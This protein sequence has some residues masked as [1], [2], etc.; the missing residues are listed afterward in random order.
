M[1]WSR[2]G[3][4]TAG[5]CLSLLL[6]AVAG[7]SAEPIVITSSS[8]QIIVRG[9]PVRQPQDA[10]LAGDSLLWLNREFAGSFWGL[11]PAA[12]NNSLVLLDPALLAVTGENIRQTLGRKLDWGS[13]WRGRI[14]INLHPVRFDRETILV[15]SIRSADGWNYELEMPDEVDAPRLVRTL[16]EV[17]LMEFANRTAGER[18]SELPPWLGPG[19]AACLRSG[20]LEVG[21]IG[22]NH[23][24][25]RTRIQRDPMEFI[26]AGLRANPVLT[27]DQLNWPA[28]DQFEE[29]KAEQ[30]DASAHLLVRELLRLGGGAE[31]LR[32]T[33]RLLPQH[34]NW[35]TAF[36]RGFQA[37]FQRMLD[38][39]KWWS[40]VV[41]GFT[42]RDPDQTWSS[43]E[44]RQR[45]DEVLYTLVQVRL[46]KDEMP[47]ESQVSLQTVLLE[48]SDVQAIPLLKNKAGQLLQVKPHLSSEAGLM[49]EAYAKVVQQYLHS[50]AQP[51]A[52][53]APRAGVSAQLRA[54]RQATIR[55]LNVLDLQRARLWDQSL[56]V[57]RDRGPRA[58]P[59]PSKPAQDRNQASRK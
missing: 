10:A 5:F 30:Y 31:C 12:G 28:D 47:H 3:R 11:R 36:F 24:V 2:V 1:A 13:D 19:L 48:W 43:A 17:L 52:E 8:K 42:G 29:D 7:N 37:H 59:A 20:A 27:V 21:V 50:L 33:L 56:P 49:A 14:F 40:L 41:V 55:R 15:R 46:A 39:E 45:L 58:K 16:V 34:L 53:R 32:E 9:Q 6:A 44:S 38:F 25:V 22:A 23:P 18:P 26:R 57:G 35:Q 54:V 51:T 4:Q